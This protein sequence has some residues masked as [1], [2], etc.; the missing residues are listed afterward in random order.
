[1]SRGTAFLAA[2]LILLVGIA[3]RAPEPEPELSLIARLDLLLRQPPPDLYA[4]RYYWVFDR[5]FIQGPISGY[6]ELQAYKT[7]DGRER[8]VL[9][10]PSGDW[11]RHLT[12][13]LFRDELEVGPAEYEITFTPRT[14]HGDRAGEPI[15]VEKDKPVE[16]SFT[17]SG[18]DGASLEPGLYRLWIMLDMHDLSP[19]PGVFHGFAVDDPAAYF[20]D[21]D[22]ARKGG[23]VFAVKAV[24]EDPKLM[25]RYLAQRAILETGQ[26][27]RPENRGPL[28][29]DTAVAH[30]RKAVE[31][32]LKGLERAPQDV[33]LLA[34]VARNLVMLND[35]DA[36]L[37]YIKAVEAIDPDYLKGDFYH[38][39]WMQSCMA[40]EPVAPQ[41]H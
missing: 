9:D 10:S 18:P 16:A 4:A 11:T 24:G 20:L 17:L 21:A 36:A 40:S 19:A 2:G 35:C 8:R 15:V 37:P 6:V 30:H 3:A 1:M 32:A 27:M 25:A 29:R 33:E 5:D 34:I 22:P 14:R 28:N 12:A 26:A 38:N 31:L 7:R 23:L 39:R 13:R 41:P